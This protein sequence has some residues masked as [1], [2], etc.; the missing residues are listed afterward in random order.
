M[1]IL[2]DPNGCGVDRGEKQRKPQTVSPGGHEVDWALCPE[3]EA[4]DALST[5]T[6]W[7]AEPE[8]R[9]LATTADDG[10][11]ERARL[12]S[13][14]TAVVRTT[15]TVLGT[16]FGRGAVGFAFA[17]MAGLLLMS[18]TNVASQPR[19]SALPVFS[20]KGSPVQNAA[21]PPTEG[22]SQLPLMPNRH[23]PSSVPQVA[24]S[25]LSLRPSALENGAESRTRPDS[26]AAAKRTTTSPL[27]ASSA[28]RSADALKRGPADKSS[29][30]PV[31]SSTSAVSGAGKDPPSPRP[32]SS[33]PTPSAH[34]PTGVDIG[35]IDDYGF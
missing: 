10:L 22:A 35:G 16:T 7:H 6:Q 1:A 26:N 20:A 19:P 24:P 29:A 13:V 4:S 23:E 8:S 28:R 32:L 17:V 21:H 18:F 33:T 5:G 25:G 2:E 9:G 11:R 34:G 14:G 3:D 12:T 31:S 30:A 15:S 27:K